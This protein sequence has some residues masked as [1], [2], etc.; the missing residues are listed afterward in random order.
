[1]YSP[2][3]KADLVE[4]LYYISRGKRGANDKGCRRNVARRDRKEKFF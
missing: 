2:K 4:K 3:I 1:M